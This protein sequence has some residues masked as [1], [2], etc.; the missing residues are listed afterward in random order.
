MVVAVTTVAS[1]AATLEREGCA[2][3]GDSWEVEA[4]LLVQEADNDQ[5]INSDSDCESDYSAYEAHVGD[6]HKYGRVLSNTMCK[7]QCFIHRESADTHPG[8]VYIAWRSLLPL[9]SNFYG[10]PRFSSLTG[11]K[12]CFT[13]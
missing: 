7:L 13:M 10:G 2:S 11:I 1:Q 3:P 5:T 12:A 9:L 6:R 4:Q 8:L